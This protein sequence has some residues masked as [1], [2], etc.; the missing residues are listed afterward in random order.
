M[1]ER[2]KKI[3]D[4]LQAAERAQ[5]DLVLAKK[6]AAQKEIKSAYRKLALECHPDKV[7]ENEKEEAEA[8]FVKVSEAYAVTT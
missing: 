8:K 6:N 1:S 7:P 4:G 2:E 5:K 3:E